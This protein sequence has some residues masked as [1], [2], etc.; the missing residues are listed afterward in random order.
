MNGFEKGELWYFAGGVG[1][2]VASVI[3]GALGISKNKHDVS[4]ER[5]RFVCKE[6]SGVTEACH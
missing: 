1:G 2:Y 3:L 6:C 5:G 4:F